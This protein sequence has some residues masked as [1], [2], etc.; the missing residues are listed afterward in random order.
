[1]MA[2][3]MMAAG[4]AP[5]AMILETVVNPANG[6]QYHLVTGEKSVDQPLGGLSWSEAHDF[7]RSL[8][9]DTGAASLL[10]ISGPEEEAWL[11]EA[12]SDPGFDL[13]S[14]L[15]LFWIGLSDREEEGRFVWEN[16]DALT[17]QNWSGIGDPVDLS[18]EKDFVYL[19][20]T[21]LFEPL[22]RRGQI[23]HHEDLRTFS[24]II[25]FSAVVEVVPEP[26]TV[27]FLSL[28]LMG[29]LRRRMVGS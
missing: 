20:N 12:F 24:G 6:H 11:M 15:N 9:G 21:S 18:G 17:Y 1:M 23:N 8:G 16:G 29:L 3:V 25:P 13:T 19:S 4:P 2:A 14:P 28:A 7:A 10:S 5:G 27:F 22:I 26:E